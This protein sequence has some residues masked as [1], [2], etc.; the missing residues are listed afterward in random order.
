MMEL[1][2]DIRFSFEFIVHSLDIDHLKTYMSSVKR[3]AEDN[4]EDTI[5]NYHFIKRD[6]CCT[7]QDV[8]EITWTIKDIPLEDSDDRDTYRWVV[9]HEIKPLIS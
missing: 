5:V 2:A 7:Q 6:I 8:L 9:M 4:F 3:E 1:I